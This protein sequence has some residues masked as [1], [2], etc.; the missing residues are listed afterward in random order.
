[1]KKQGNYI[2]L[3]FIVFIWGWTAIL[4]KLITVSAFDLT[5]YRTGIAALSIL[6]FLLY[7]KAPIR[8]TRTGL[9]RF[10]GVGTV[11]ALHWIFFYE[12]VKIN[13]S[14]GLVC[15]SSGTF[16]VSFIEPLF[17]KRKIIWYEVFF[18]TVV[19]GIIYLISDTTLAVKP[20]LHYLLEAYLNPNQAV[21][22][23][24]LLGAFTSALFAVLNGRLVRTYDPKTITFYEMIGGF[25]FMTLYFLLTNHFSISFFQLSGA[26]WLWLS[27]LSVACTAFTFVVSVSI[28]KEI[29]P[30][31][32]VLSVNL[33]PVYGIILA[34]LIFHEQMHLSFYL[35]TGV[36]LALVFGNALLKSYFRKAD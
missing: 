1:M 25:C 22:I 3:H 15:F 2:L 30:Y 5:W 27:I 33:E 11:V 29:S 6:A 9:L 21:V 32:V 35:E 12:A 24:S 16:F 26:D 34:W 10:F 18:G 28:M 19:F 13:V 23:F 4:G 8:T 36:I 14:V 31:T 20:G 7:Q 17:Y